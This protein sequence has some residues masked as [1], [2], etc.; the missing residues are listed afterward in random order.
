MILEDVKTIPILEVAHGL[1]L[2]PRGRSARCFSHRPDRHPSLVFNPQ[3]NR[4]KCYVCPEIHGSVIDLVMQVRECSFKEAIEVLEPYAGEPIQY[5]QP[6]FPH[7]GH[8]S[9]TLSAEYKNMIFNA[10]LQTAPLEK[11]GLRYLISRG[12]DPDAALRM[13]IGFLR[14]EAYQDLFKALIKLYGR[15]ALRRSGLTHFFLLAKEGLSF[16]L[17]PYR[18]GNLTH[19]IKARCL[20]TKEEAGRRNIRRFV[21]TEPAETLYNQDAIQ[22]ASQLYLCEGEIDTLTM[23]QRGYPAIGIPGVSSF[24]MDWFKL[25]AGKHVV[26]CLDNDAVWERASHWFTT[27]FLR[28]GISHSRFALPAGMDINQYFNQRY[29]NRKEVRIGQTKCRST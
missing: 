20:L 29:F 6:V 4:F 15:S 5:R 2:E 12:I 9:S 24:R 10:L 7:N 16:L 21:A 25:L 18:A 22:S 26:L 11:E 8:R 19:L 1:G 13:G 3:T 27:E 14:P 17:F 23:I 28:H